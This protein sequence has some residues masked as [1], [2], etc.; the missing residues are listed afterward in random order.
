MERPDHDD[1]WLM[2]EVVQDLD[3]A[4]TDVG[5]ER[6]IP[7]D[8]ESLSY[9]AIQRGLRVTDKTTIEPFAV[10]WID[11][12]TAGLNFQKRRANTP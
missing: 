8:I 12:F 9:M 6:T 5:I 2:A 11:G 10:A 4:A 1:F 7:V 3:D